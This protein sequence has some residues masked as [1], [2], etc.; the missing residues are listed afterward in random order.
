MR[1]WRREPSLRLR[2]KAAPVLLE[3]R[4]TTIAISYLNCVTVRCLTTAKFFWLVTI[5]LQSDESLPPQTARVEFVF[6]SPRRPNTKRD[7]QH[8]AEDHLQ[9][10]PRYDQCSDQPV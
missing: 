7:D 3:S 2:P 1:R 4:A 5:L 8:R 9:V 6:G 10:W